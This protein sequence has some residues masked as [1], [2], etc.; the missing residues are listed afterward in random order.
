MRPTDLVDLRTIAPPPL[1]QLRY[2]TSD[3]LA[4]APIYPPT[5]PALLLEPAATALGVATA[6]GRA[7]GFNLCVWDAYRPPSAQ[8]RLWELNPDPKFVAP[9][10]RGS[11]HQRGL[12][13]DVTLAEL[14]T[15]RVLDLGTGFDD[16][17]ARAARD[18]PDLP[19]AVRERRCQLT[20]VME[21][22]GFRGLNAEWW[23]FDWLGW[24][25]YPL[26]EWEFPASPSANTPPPPGPSAG[27][28]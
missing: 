4:G 21:H 6:A 12:A 3:N 23:H 13:V 14:A 20:E 18:F 28:P 24:E 15:G 22:A 19:P 16:F 8:R 5:A 11:R 17:T 27:P 25:N 7:L 1:I 9:P 26:L 2:A 10:S